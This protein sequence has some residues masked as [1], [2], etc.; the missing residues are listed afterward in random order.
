MKKHRRMKGEASSPEVQAH[1]GK[2]AGA[3]LSEDELK[4]VSGGGNIDLIS[5]S[6]GV[7]RGVS[8]GDPSDQQGKVPSVS[9]LIVK[10]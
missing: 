7:G 8:P 5:W 10:P 6:L 3:P 9:N 4:K 2:K 1:A